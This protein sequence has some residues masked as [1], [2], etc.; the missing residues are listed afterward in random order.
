MSYKS[1][2]SLIKLYEESIPSILH[3]SL[4]VVGAPGLVRDVDE[5]HQP[6]CTQGGV[7]TGGVRTGCVYLGVERLG[8][9]HFYIVLATSG[10]MGH[11]LF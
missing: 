1:F 7:K 4:C 10:C 2:W 9:S 8:V 6:T 3:I 11:S 5:F